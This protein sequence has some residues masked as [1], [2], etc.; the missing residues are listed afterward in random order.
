MKR[1]Y[2]FPDIR[3]QSIDE[4]DGILEASVALPV[5]DENNPNTVP[6]D[7]INSGKE[8]LGNGS[9]VWDYDEE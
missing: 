4:E 6:D 8:V 2:L 5:F 1:T 9:S 3:I 7:L